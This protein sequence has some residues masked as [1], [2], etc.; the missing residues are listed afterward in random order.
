MA[1]DMWDE[2]Y[3]SADYAYGKTANEFL[4]A[5]WR[6]IPGKA[7]LSIAEGE[8]RNAVFL[9]QQGLAVTAV[10]GSRVGLA[11]AGRLAEEN[12]VAL[13]CV[14]ADLAGYDFGRER[15]DGIVSIFCPLP[16][17]LRRAV[18]RK[19]VAALKPGGAYLVE[20]YR[21]AQIAYGTGGGSD[22][23][24]M[25]T[26]DSLREELEGLRFERL[27]EVDRII[28][29]GRFHTGMSAVVQ[30]IARKPG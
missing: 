18:H 1:N 15:W 11:K 12:G 3:A 2:R 19:V 5:H 28:L 8:G 21:P 10:D 29:E 25:M 22:P 17:D 7:V 13:D 23:T 6:A 30:V 24:T 20:A 27:V 14:Q 16:A 9:A 26:L 4:Q